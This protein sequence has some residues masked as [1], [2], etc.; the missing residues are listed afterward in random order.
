MAADLNPDRLILIGGGVGRLDHIFAAIGALG[1]PT[2]TSVPQLEAWW[3]RHHLRVVHGPGRA[4]LE[5]APGTTLSL[6]ATHGPCRGV[7]ISGVEWPLD[8]ADLAPLAGLGVSNVALEPEVD[9]A[10]S[11]GVLT[12][13]V[14]PHPDSPHHHLEDTS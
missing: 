1:R 7:T 8:R 9:I 4:E 11:S 3:A 2:M 10:V 5:L 14:P 13:I 6:L 12:V